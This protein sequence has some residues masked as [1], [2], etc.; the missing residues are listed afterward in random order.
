MTCYRCELCEEIRD[1][2]WIG[3]VQHPFFPDML[4]C[5]CCEEEL[6]QIELEEKWGIR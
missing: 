1:A 2:D 3:C 5:E 6:E 4:I